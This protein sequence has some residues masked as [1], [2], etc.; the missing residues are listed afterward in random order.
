MTESIPLKSPLAGLE[1]NSDTAQYVGMLEG[2][3]AALVVNEMKYRTLL[4]LLTGDSWDGGELDSDPN[5][6]VPLAV[7]ALVKQTNLDENKAKKLV[8]QRLGKRRDTVVPQPV[9]ASIPPRPEH[10]VKPDMSERFKAWKA[11]QESTDVT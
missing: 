7:S 3:I 1:M 6:L 4:E 11:K 8:S 10:A 5:A 9:S 2:T